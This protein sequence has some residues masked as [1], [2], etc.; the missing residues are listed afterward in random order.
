MNAHVAGTD[1]SASAEPLWAAPD[2]SESYD[3][4]D[5]NAL[6]ASAASERAASA[7]GIPDSSAGQGTSAALASSQSDAMQGEADQKDM[8]QS[9]PARLLTPSG[10][11]A[12]MQ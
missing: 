3:S 8:Q 7:S 5:Q 4:P 1:S 12:Q 2:S 9:S 6:D 10:I 11:V